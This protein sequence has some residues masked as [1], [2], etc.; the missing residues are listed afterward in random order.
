MAFD[1]NTNALI[2]AV[3]VKMGD[4]QTTGIS[5]TQTDGNDVK[6][7]AANGTVTVKAASA[8]TVSLYTHAGQ[9]L[10]Q[11]SG[12]REASINVSGYHGPVIVKAVNG[13][14]VT[15]QKVILK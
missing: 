14:T 6:V 4:I 9:L 10:G 13:S 1:G 2:N 12:N 5:D 7:S 11:A 8:V 3:L 15:T